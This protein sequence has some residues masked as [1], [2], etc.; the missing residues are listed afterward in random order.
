MCQ[1]ALVSCKQ[2]F[3][4]YC[5]G[6]LLH[7]LSK[8]DVSIRFVQVFVEFIDFVFVH[9]SDRIVNSRELERESFTVS[10]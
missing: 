7:L 10:C 9:I 3:V 1:C 4:G 6:V 2:W 5:Y 8:L